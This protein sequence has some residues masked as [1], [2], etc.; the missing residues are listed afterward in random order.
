M[1]KECMNQAMHIG[2]SKDMGGNLKPN[3]TP[4]PIKRTISQVTER[5]APKGKQ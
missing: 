4:V 2:P 3:L 5:K 1:D